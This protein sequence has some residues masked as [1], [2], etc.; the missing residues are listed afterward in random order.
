MMTKKKKN[1]F[2]HHHT[3]VGKCNLATPQD[4]LERTKQR[5][6]DDRKPRT[7]STAGIKR[8]RGRPRK[9]I[10]KGATCH[11]GDL[12]SQSKS[13]LIAVTQLQA[14]IS[15]IGSRLEHLESSERRQ[16]WNEQAEATRSML[17][18]LTRNVEHLQD[19]IK[20]NQSILEGKCE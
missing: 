4:I 14:T 9:A 6:L 7:S 1:I 5:F 11:H 10:S 13:A 12:V 2:D 19:F 18:A 3:Y 16:A 17:T 8:P 15:T 20:N